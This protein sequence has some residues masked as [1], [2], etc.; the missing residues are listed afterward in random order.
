M[1]RYIRSRSFL[2]VYLGESPSAKTTFR[3]A[4]VY[5]GV[6]AG[7]STVPCFRYSKYSFPKYK[8][9]LSPCRRGDRFSLFSPALGTRLSRAAPTSY[10]HGLRTRTFYYV[11]GVISHRDARDDLISLKGLRRAGRYSAMAITG[12]RRVSGLDD[13]G[14]LLLM[15][16]VAHCPCTI[17]TKCHD[18]QYGILSNF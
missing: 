17:V 15:T 13:G 16:R 12:A 1:A 6:R 3:L 8:I 14:P 10:Y 9:L 18:T 7:A 5:A 2:R 4:D 11:L